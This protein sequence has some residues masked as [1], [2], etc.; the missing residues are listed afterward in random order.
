[1][2]CKMAKKMLGGIILGTG[3]IE[4]GRANHLELTNVTLVSYQYPLAVVQPP[5]GGNFCHQRSH[6]G[7]C[8][9]GLLGDHGVEWQPL[10]A[11]R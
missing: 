9:C 11:G 1:M 5:S 7:Q 6:A 8:G 10:G 3:L 2:N 4:M